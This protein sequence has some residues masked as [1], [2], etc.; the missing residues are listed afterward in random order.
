MKIQ[1]IAIILLVLFL[2]S[3][4]IIA[5]SYF[6]SNVKTTI[7]SE[8]KSI[9]SGQSFWVA[10]KFEMQNG[11]HIY[12]R[13]SGDSGLPT[14]VDWIVPKGFTITDTFYPYPNILVENNSATFIY[15]NEVL[16]LVKITSPSNIS[17]NEIVISAKA[18]WLEC[19]QVCI[20]G[21]AK[22]TVTL[23][24]D[25]S[26]SEDEIAISD[27]YDWLNK[28]PIYKSDWKFEI[29]ISN[30][31]VNVNGIKPNWFKSNEYEIIFFPYADDIFN[32]S[33]K[34]NFQINENGFTIELELNKF[35]SEDPSSLDGI[36]VI[37]DSWIDN[38]KKK[39]LEFSESI[40]INKEK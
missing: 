27:L 18:N 21:S 33:A 9:K 8:V 26:N 6:D 12:W 35:R 10:V 32:Y 1:R 30:N 39:S 25:D 7:I 11:W 13:N 15:E 34:Q 19:K 24:V 5:G 36:L 40:I 17:E 16:L 31:L 14:S 22:M 4:F 20:P 2:C 3:Q 29:E 28:V 37:S 23:N 38:S